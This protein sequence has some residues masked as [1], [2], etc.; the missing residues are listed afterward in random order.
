MKAS[1]SISVFILFFGFCY[2]SRSI[3]IKNK[4]EEWYFKFLAYMCLSLH[5]ANFLIQIFPSQGVL[6]AQP[7]S[8]LF[9]CV[10]III[11]ISSLCCAVYM[12]PALLTVGFVAAFLNIS[13]G[14]L[15]FTELLLLNSV[16]ASG[17]YCFF[18][19]LFQKNVR[20]QKMNRS[21]S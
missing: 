14:S 8:L 20:R 5:A 16:L 19:Y 10:T 15:G 4:S 2:L 21:S 9:K 18:S 11:S 13:T 1:F 7:E 3:V 17:I 12:G 6:Q